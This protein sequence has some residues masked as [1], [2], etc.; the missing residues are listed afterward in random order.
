MQ[1]NK[2]VLVDVDAAEQKEFDNNFYDT[3]EAGSMHADYRYTLYDEP[4]HAWPQPDE[5]K[6]LFE[7]PSPSW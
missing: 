2:V 7:V 3:L 5:V 4:S 6:V 1:K